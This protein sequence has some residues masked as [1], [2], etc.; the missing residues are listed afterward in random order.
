VSK[1][2]SVTETTANAER[3]IGPALAIAWGADLP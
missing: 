2:D 1:L 3:G